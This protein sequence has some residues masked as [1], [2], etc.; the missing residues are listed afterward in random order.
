MGKELIRVAKRFAVYALCLALLF[1]DSSRIGSSAE[2]TGENSVDSNSPVDL[3]DKA[4]E[5]QID[6]WNDSEVARIS[7]DLIASNAGYTIV[8]EGSRRIFQDSSDYTLSVNPLNIDEYAE[9]INQYQVYNNVALTDPVLFEL[10]VK[11]TEKIVEEEEFVD[12][13]IAADNHSGYREHYSGQ[14][15]A[16][17]LEEEA[18][19]VNTA[20]GSSEV[21][22]SSG[23][24]TGNPSSGQPG[25]HT[26]NQSGNHTSNQS[27]TQPGS[28]TGSQPGGHDTT[29]PEEK[30]TDEKP[31]D[32]KPSDE[33][34]SEEKPSDEKPTDEKPSE[35]K[36]SEEKPSD[37]KPSDE[38]PSE[39]NPGDSG[40]V[41]INGG[42]ATPN[43]A[44]YMLDDAQPVKDSILSLVEVKENPED[45]ENPE[46]VEN[47]EDIENPDDIENPMSPAENW[48]TLFEEEVT[49]RIFT[50]TSFTGL[51]LYEIND[52]T[53]TEIAFT[54][55]N[56]TTVSFQTSHIG[57]YV[58]ALKN[59]DDDT[60]AK[61]QKAVENCTLMS[62]YIGQDGQVFSFK[63]NMFNYTAEPLNA[64]TK[65]YFQVTSSKEY[66]EFNK[67]AGAACYNINNAFRSKNS[68][69]YDAALAGIVQSELNKDSLEPVF[70]VNAARLFSTS[71]EFGN[72]YYNGELAKRTYTNVDFPFLYQDGYYVFDS[73]N[74]SVLANDEFYVNDTLKGYT[75]YHNNES[76]GAWNLA[77]FWP[78]A[79]E[80]NKKD[81]HFGMNLAVGFTMNE[82]GTDRNGNP[83]IYEFAGDDDVWV[84][85]D[86]K[87]VLDIGGI[88]GRVSG[89]INFETG[90]VCVSR[91]AKLIQNADGSFTAE[92]TATDNYTTHLEDIFGEGYFDNAKTM[93]TLRIFYTERGDY[94]SNCKMKFNLD[95]YPVET[96]QNSYRVNGTKTAKLV[97]WDDRTYEITIGAN[98]TST[99]TRTVNGRKLAPVG[100][101]ITNAVIK[102]VIDN[103]FMITTDEIARLTS[104]EGGNAT[105]T[106][107][108]D[109]YPYYVVT[110]SGQTIQYGTAG[111]T[112][113]RKINVVARNTY[114]GGNDVPTNVYGDSKITYPDKEG[115]KKDVTLPLPHVNVKIPTDIAG[116]YDVIFKG[117][118]LAQYFTKDDLNQFITVDSEGVLTGIGQYT[119]IRDITVTDYYFYQIV[120]N[121]IVRMTAEDIRSERPYQD[122]VYNFRISFKLNSRGNQTT[123]EMTIETDNGKQFFVN[124]ISQHY[125]MNSSYRVYVFTAEVTVTKEVD[126]NA[127]DFS[128]GDPIFTFQLIGDNGETY[129]KS[130]RFTKNQLTEGDEKAYAS[131]TFTGLHKG[132]YTLNELSTIRYQLDSY[133]DVN[134]AP[135]ILENTINEE[136]IVVACSNNGI[137]PTFTFMVPQYE[138]ESLIIPED[139]VNRIFKGYATAYNKKV[140]EYYDSDTDVV[141]NKFIIINGGLMEIDQD[142][143]NDVRKVYPSN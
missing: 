68:A 98:S 125:E 34:P 64:Y 103:R 52:A 72:I 132:T 54:I 61:L 135:A 19:D 31:S 16:G 85:I 70:N 75:L 4:V 8:V 94:E 56:D 58:F 57:K 27:G 46:D 35:E 120:N 60:R 50:T 90:D 74:M 23:V 39:E 32:E 5:P 97:N 101:D 119:D 124:D 20:N 24:E 29:S 140:L 38:K 63:A 109:N 96:S 51:S 42:D 12:P 7:G 77:G 127:L 2:E 26:G 114:F 28:H 83:I 73:D 112:W 45:I 55:E 82:T 53:L 137:A 43:V 10:S 121:E 86:D 87:L 110:W 67:G 62:E 113:E 13:I 6:D 89:T 11:E 115:N 100:I 138:Q 129:Y 33:K 30:P 92:N 48:I 133:T 107:P 118:S 130:V 76:K 128:T 105:V 139:D 65:E 88:H 14:D 142:Y 3:G 66:L 102:D 136:Q 69:S 80:M 79:K 44:S 59:V 104:D 126:V 131:V 17:E 78:F 49:V 122:T 108:T 47:P 117:E 143:L 91:S 15:D 1:A 141:V 123:K 36:P 99:T 134:V 95:A 116:S 37:E 9:L 22:G 93:H 18:T 40:N 25:G 106:L 81:V 111:N 21:S 71:G 84:F 41:P